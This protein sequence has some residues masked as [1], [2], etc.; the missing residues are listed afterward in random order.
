MSA[1]AWLALGALLIL[2]DPMLVHLSNANLIHWV[3][4]LD[5]VASAI[6]LGSGATCF[7]VGIVGMAKTRKRID[8]ERP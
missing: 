2:C 8:R 6:L 1:K 3:H 4:P 5:R 7:I